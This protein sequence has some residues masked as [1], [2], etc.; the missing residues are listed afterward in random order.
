MGAAEDRLTAEQK[1]IIE[2]CYGKV[3]RAKKVRLP[4]ITSFGEG[5]S[6]T[7]GRVDPSNWGSTNINEEDLDPEAQQAALDS[8]EQNRR[9][10]PEKTGEMAAIRGKKVT[11][12]TNGDSSRRPVPRREQV[13]TNITRLR[14]TR[15][16]II[17]CANLS[18][19]R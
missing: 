17:L 6:K 14:R 11:P 10:E 18:E 16:I 8:I 12:Q 4:S 2:R 9:K 7:K 19:K 15:S 13:M 1:N 3:S 5:P